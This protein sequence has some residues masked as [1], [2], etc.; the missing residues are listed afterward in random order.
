MPL[1]LCMF[2]L[3]SSAARAQHT[4]TVSGTQILEDGSPA[5]FAGVNA[6]G[7]FGPNASSMKGY[8]I[9]IVREGMTD[10]QEQPISGSGITVSTKYGTA[11]LHSLQEVVNNNRANGKVT[12]FV[13]GY[14]QI[15]G[16]QLAGQTPSKQVFFPELEAKVK[17]IAAYFKDQ[18]D[19]WLEV[20]NEPYSA[21]NPPSWLSDMKAMVDNIRAAG[22]NNIVLVPGSNWDSSEDVILSQ[23]KTLLNGRSNLLF[24]L[25]TYDW[26]AQ[27]AGSNEARLQALKAAGFPIIVGEVGPEYG[28]GEIQDPANFLAAALN[29]KV[30]TLL[31]AWNYDYNSKDYNS[32]F[33]NSGSATPWGQQGFNFLTSLLNGGP[34]AGSG[35]PAPMAGGNFAPNVWYTIKNPHSNLCIEAANGSTAN[36]TRVQQNPCVAGD[37]A[38]QWRFEAAATAGGKSYFQVQNRKATNEAWDIAQASHLLQV[39][40]YGGAGNEWWL[41]TY[42]G[43]DAYTFTV[44]DSG[45][46]L[47]VP[48]ASTAGG[49]QLWEYVCNGTGAQS[50]QLTPQQ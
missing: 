9:N 3:A 2:S 34:A 1:A 15:K 18:P 21:P 10:V 27:S 42:L 44:S 20:W 22:N 43:N 45:N 4:Y 13:P 49:V 25:H 24:D 16:S 36:G 39:Y 48:G 8:S 30:S 12:I 50:F 14:W 31:W 41:P 40:Q 38:Q 37:P 26:G 35:N 23:G 47:D 46:C 7:I 17:Q 19:V 5:I 32:L 28:D 29:Q 6:F 33:F 11:Y